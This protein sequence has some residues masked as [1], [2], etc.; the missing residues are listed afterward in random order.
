MDYMIALYWHTT[1]HKIINAYSP[2]HADVAIARV[3]TSVLNKRIKPIRGWTTCSSK[4]LVFYL[5]YT[6]L[7]HKLTI[8]SLLVR[9]STRKG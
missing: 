5:I 7:V 6:D 8:K 2:L 3:M 1:I 4:L 9:V